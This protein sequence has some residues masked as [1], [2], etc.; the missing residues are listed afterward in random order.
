MATLKKNLSGTRAQTRSGRLLLAKRSC[1]AIHGSK[2]LRAP[3]ATSPS[4]WCPENEEDRP[5][6][7]RVC[8]SNSRV[9]AQE[10]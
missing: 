1:R 8:S 2:S 6:W 5:K 3:T 10:A 7:L 9:E 4:P